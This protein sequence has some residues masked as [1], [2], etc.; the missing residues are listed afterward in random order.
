MSKPLLMLFSRA[1]NNKLT[2]ES[3]MSDGV[4]PFSLVIWFGGRC[5]LSGQIKLHVQPRFG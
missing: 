2:L 4:L 5:L 1:N 3:L